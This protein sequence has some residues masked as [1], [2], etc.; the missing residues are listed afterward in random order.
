[1][2]KV[3]FGM[4]MLSF[5]GCNSTNPETGTL[6]AHKEVLSHADYNLI[7]DNDTVEGTAIEILNAGNL[8][9]TSGQIVVCDPLVMPNSKPLARSV[10]T[11]SYPVKLY[12]AKTVEAG[13]RFA[14]AKLEFNSNK[15]VK[16]VLAL[17]AGE[18]VTEL[19]NGDFFGFP[20]D[21]GLG[22]FFDYATG[23]T[24]NKF[25]DGIMRANPDGN[26]YDDLLAAEFKKNAKNPNE[27]N[28]YGDW[29]N[30]KVPKSNSNIIMFQSGYGDG[31]YP[32]YWGID[33][34]GEVTSLVID[35]FVLLAPDYEE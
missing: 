10:K 1:M 14:I 11:G 6:D 21:A 15:A 4:F 34:N 25:Y 16:W 5:L 18:N 33:E 2:K 19:K 24:Y 26:I 3:L 35:F 22:A 31:A 32:A 20:V 30:F 17:K 27:P 13:D 9:V 23:A 8:E 7:F 29:V 12:V 28:D